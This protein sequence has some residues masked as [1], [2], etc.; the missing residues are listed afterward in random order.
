[1]SSY[2]DSSLLDA[3]RSL[4]VDGHFVEVLSRTDDT[5][6]IQTT[7][8]I[9]D[10]DESGPID[11]LC[12]DPSILWVGDEP[13]S[14]CE[15]FTLG[16]MNDAP[17]HG[18]IKCPFC[19]RQTKPWA[20]T[21]RT[22]TG[23]F[24]AT[25]KGVAH[26]TRG[27]AVHWIMSD[28]LADKIIA[29]CNASMLV[30]NPA[31]IFAEGR[32]PAL[33]VFDLDYTLW[34]FDCGMDVMGPF[35]PDP[36]DTDYVYDRNEKNANVFN[37]V[38]EII[39]SL[40]DAGIPIAYASRNCGKDMIEDLL[41]ATCISPM[42]RPDIKNLWEALP[43][44]DYFQAYSSSFWG[45]GHGLGKSR[46]FAAI[47]NSTGVKYHEMLF[48]DDLIENIRVAR[49]QGTTSVHLGPKGLTW[50]T[51]QEGMQEWRK[52]HA[53]PIEVEEEEEVPEIDFEALTP[54]RHSLLEAENI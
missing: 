25:K 26:M 52:A 9:T 50:E 34:P 12:V 36:Y 32:N 11:C 46:H 54:V 8:Y 41:R 40:L 31:S 30:K 13:C 1:M 35:I 28:E 10:S 17:P 22:Y 51:M 44:R 20:L 24:R 21:K 23:M 6:K 33:C 16:L 2:F 14:V 7:S 53:P 37:D 15:S 4:R 29:V 27:A 49:I 38:R 19:N 48:F 39:E 45:N 18:S 5:L 42:L 3:L 47:K 43:S